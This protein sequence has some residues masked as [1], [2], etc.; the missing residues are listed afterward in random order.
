M[1]SRFQPTTPDITKVGINW[2][3]TGLESDLVVRI[4]AFRQRKS[5]QTNGN[6]FKNP[7]SPFIHDPA[8]Y[9]K[10]FFV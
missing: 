4:I 1:N 5:S 2:S 6:S 3:L 7:N 10:S 8:H 9:D